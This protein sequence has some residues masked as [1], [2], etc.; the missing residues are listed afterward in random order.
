[1]RYKPDVH[2]GVVMLH[3]HILAHEDTGAMSQE[4]IVN[5][6]TCECN[7]F[8]DAKNTAFPSATPT[9][10]PSASPVREPNC[11]FRSMI[12]RFTGQIA[13]ERK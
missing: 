5:H 4:L 7:V 6:G 2:D 3:C 8:R 1:M 10:T 11:F 9:V 12:E 13:G